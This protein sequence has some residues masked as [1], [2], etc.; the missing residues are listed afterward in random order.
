MVSLLHSKAAIERANN[1]TVTHLSFTSRGRDLRRK[2]RLRSE[3]DKL[4]DRFF[5]NWHLSKYVVLSIMQSGGILFAYDL[6]G[7]PKDNRS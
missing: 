2:R 4:N 6:A 3:E 7:L 1:L 5:Y